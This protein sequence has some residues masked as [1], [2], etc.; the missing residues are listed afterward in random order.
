MQLV[1][2]RGARVVGTAR[3]GSHDFLA[4]LGAIP[5]SYGPGLAERV[6]SLGLGLPDLALD[7]AGA[8]SLEELIAATGALGAVVTLADFT[9]QATCGH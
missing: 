3:A 2:A 9:G 4:N 1:T 8:G 7:V 6:R 5:V